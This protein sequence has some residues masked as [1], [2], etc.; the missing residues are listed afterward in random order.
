MT[1]LPNNLMQNP[2]AMAAEGQAPAISI[3]DLE[4]MYTDADEADKELFAEQRSNILLVMGEHYNRRQSNFFKRLRD[5]RQISQEQKIR[6][7]KNHIQ[8]ISDAYVNNIMAVAPS[9]GFEPAQASELQDQKA[10]E[11]N[12]SVWE[13]AKD[14]NNLDEETQNWCEDFVQVGEVATKIFFDQAT[15][16]IIF[17]EIFGFNLLVDPAATRSKKAR[18]MIVRKMVDVK[19][20]KQMFPGEEHAKFIQASADQTYTI[21]DRGRGAYQKS[22]DQC[23]VREFYIRPSEQYKNGYYFIT[24]KDHILDSGEL[25]GGIFPIVFKPFKRMPTRA[26]GQSVIKTLRPFQAEVNRAASKIAEHQITLGDDKLVVQK[27]TSVTAG[28]SLPGVRT[29]SVTG[30]SPTVLPGRD[31][32]QY[33]QYMASQITEMYNAASVEEKMEDISGNI[34]VYTLLFRSARQKRTFNI[35]ISR[36]EQF[37]KEVAATYLELARYHYDDDKIVAMIGANERVNIEEFRNMSPLCY[38]IKITAQAEDIETKMGKQLS[39]TQALQYVGSKME[40]EDI[41]KLMRAMPYANKEE[42]FSDFTL[43]YDAATNDILALDRGELPPIHETDN[44]TYMIKRLT[45]RMRQADFQYLDQSIQNN[46]AARLQAHEQAA[47]MIA[48]QL[49][50]AEAGFIPT[51]GYLVACDFY[52][53]TDANDPSKTKRVRLPSEAL[54]WLI[55]KLETQGASLAQLESVND[56]NLIQIAQM[57]GNGEGGNGMPSSPA[58][59]QMGNAM[60]GGV[61]NVRTGTNPDPNPGFSGGST[62]NPNPGR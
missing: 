34:D 28:A 57:M 29:I 46:Y 26:R 39:I 4:K 37:L 23:M 22:K 53:Q 35:Y 42:C 33:A 15:G 56:A 43:D 55:Q 44:H 18:H 58:S 54:D 32:S 50:A 27:G 10:A 45:N 19:K 24:V 59:Q 51:G 1:N 6:L 9:V 60:P 7:T 30:M 40:K 2:Q 38:K 12:H 36:F 17:E 48:K 20:L 61:P 8:K 49:Q 41:G 11:M 25:P 16:E 52:V 3:A 13:Y 31:G 14:K 5:T 21:F 47:A 62:S